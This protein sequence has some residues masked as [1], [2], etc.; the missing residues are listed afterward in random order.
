MDGYN[1]LSG[2][3]WRGVERGADEAAIRAA[4]H[5]AA[6]KQMRWTARGWHREDLERLH[7]AT[8]EDEACPAR[9]PGH[10]ATVSVY[11]ERPFLGG[12]KT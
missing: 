12:G 4:V 11:G 7:A 10:S 5:D 9:T 3:V 8:C 2:A 6:V 1:L